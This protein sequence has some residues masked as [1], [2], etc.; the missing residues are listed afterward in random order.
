MTP[1]AP[2]RR[3]P[4]PLRALALSV[5]AAFTALA[6]LTPLEALAA[7]IPGSDEAAVFA[8]AGLTARDGAYFREACPTPLKPAT[9]RIDIDRDGRDEVALFMGPSGC[10]GQSLGGNVAL[11]MKGADGSWRELLGYAPGV[12]LVPVGGSTQGFIDLGLAS[13]GGCMAVMRWNGQAYAH[14]LNRAIEPGG[15]QFR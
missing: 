11:F 5:A 4:L 2:I 10:F 6:A 7:P 8:A 12:E 1:L 13:P 3:L 14:A 15:C 9:E